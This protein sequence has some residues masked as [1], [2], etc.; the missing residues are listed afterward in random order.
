VESPA[1]TDSYPERNRKIERWDKN[2]KAGCVRLTAALSLH[3]AKR[4]VNKC[5]ACHNAVRSP[6]ANAYINPAGK[7]AGCTEATRAA[8]SETVCPIHAEAIQFLTDTTGPERQR[9]LIA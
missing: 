9:L 7:L 6:G 1:A 3:D 4:L 5:V 2:L 8:S